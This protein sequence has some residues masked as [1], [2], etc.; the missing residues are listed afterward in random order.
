MKQL[1]KYVGATVNLENI[2][3][4]QWVKDLGFTCRYLPDPPEDFD[5]FAFV[6]DLGELKN[7]GLMVTVELLKIKRTLFGLIAPD[8][9][10]CH[11]LERRSG[12]RYF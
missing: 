3:N 7:P 1:R 4:T 9:S 8:N 2:K 10:C 5:E 11:R 12:R 6:T